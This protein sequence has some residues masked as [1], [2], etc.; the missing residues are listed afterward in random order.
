VRT[1]YLGTSSFAAAVLE[2][3]AAS[4]HRPALVVTRPDAP[5]GRGQRLQ[6]PPVADTARALGI[7]LIQPERLHDD[8]VLARIAA[9]EPGAVAVCAYGALIREPLLGDY[10]IL[11]VHPSLLPRWRGA[12]P[13][14]RAIMAGDAVTGI[15][16]IRLV[17]ALDAGP[18]CLQ[19]E[20]PIG[21]DDDF[22]TL[23]ARLERLGGELLVRAL[24][25]RPPYA[26]QP[27]EG[28]T[29]AHKIEARDRALDP[30]LPADAVE[31][32]VRAL[33]PHIGARL[34]LPSGEFLGVLAAR[35]DGETLAPAG[36]R[37]RVDEGRLLLDCNGAAL[38][39]TEIRPPG[40]KPMEASAWLRGRPDTAMTGYFLDPS[41][42]DRSFDD[43][44]RLARDE[45]TSD[46]EWAPYLS[47]LAYRGDE[48]VLFRARGMTEDGDPLERGIAAFLLGQLGT[49]VRTFPA[50][51]AAALEAMAEHE[52]DTGVLEA[53]AHGFGH[54]GE[55]YGL[56]TLLRLSGHEDARVR[57]AAAIALAGRG[58][59]P[60]VD[61]LI[62]LSR[63]EESD[64][65]DWATF[66][67]GMLS[68]HD[69]QEL[70]EALVDRLGDADAETR[71]E[72]VH[73]LAVRGDARA[74]EPALELLAEAARTEGDGMWRRLELRETAQRLAAQT[75]DE[76][77]EPYL[78]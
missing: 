26:D 70:R 77:F 19:G 62:R 40:G 8:D 20:E 57:E 7:E 33:R 25:E 1:V 51:S 32:Q 18:V 12:A 48:E 60:A 3:L 78:P 67:L 36:G 58:A 13:I 66:A 21:P 17:E 34:A 55:P 6:P 73:G 68:A 4:E 28:V 69:T 61:A 56:D 74:V 14:E 52:Q 72:A 65:R 45:W 29:Y 49:P 37:V 24:A 41:L 31:R 30:T 50:E 23:S 27:A 59:A 44:L 53:I 46:A 71:L 5:R 64:V 76:R 35:V 63:D 10:E 22:G 75:G 9:A 16:I 47:A 2:R 38:E 39:L 42:P 54:L 11:N 43:L 15:S